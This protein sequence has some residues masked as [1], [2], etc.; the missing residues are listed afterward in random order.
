M[1]H[2]SPSSRVPPWFPLPQ[3]IIAP[4][5]NEVLV[6]WM[7]PALRRNRFNDSV[8]QIPKHKN[9]G[10]ATISSVFAQPVLGPARSGFRFKDHRHSAIDSCCCGRTRLDS[11]HDGAL[12]F[13]CSRTIR[14]EKTRVVR[15]PRPPCPPGVGGK[16]TSSVTS[17]IRVGGRT[18]R[19]RAPSGIA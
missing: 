4:R 6:D 18:R 2:L 11:S 9:A 1:I 17:R 3:P 14:S 8:P 12:S 7:V 15:T 19:G 10:K 5:N 16:R 13:R